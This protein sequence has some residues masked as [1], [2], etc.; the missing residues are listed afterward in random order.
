MIIIMNIVF[1]I[2]AIAPEVA[3]LDAGLNSTSVAIKDTVYTVELGRDFQVSCISTGNF[4]GV[5]TWYKIIED[6][7]TASF[8][9]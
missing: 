4:S 9:Q 2:L 6:T 1:C 7:G 8:T 5:V 3:V